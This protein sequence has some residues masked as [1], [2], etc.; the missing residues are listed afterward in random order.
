MITIRKAK[1]TL[2]VADDHFGCEP[3]GIVTPKGIPGFE[4]L[5]RTLKVCLTALPASL[6]K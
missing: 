4:H 5:E 6:K 3:G 2:S 1:P